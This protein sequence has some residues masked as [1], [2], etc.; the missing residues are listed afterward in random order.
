MVTHVQDAP[1][2]IWMI[3]VM[4]GRL[5]IIM[6]LLG[7]NLPVKTCSTLVFQSE[8]LIIKYV[9]KYSSARSRTSRAKVTSKVAR[10]PSK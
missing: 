5:G 6:G 7:I 9:L 10:V 4:R 2:H 3:W 1:L 8:L